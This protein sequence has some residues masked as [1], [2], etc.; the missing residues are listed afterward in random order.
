MHS[1]SILTLVEELDSCQMGDVRDQACKSFAS[2]LV[3]SQQ[4]CSF[5]HFK[6][7][8]AVIWIS[9]LLMV[10]NATFDTIPVLSRRSDLLV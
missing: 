7:P 3:V 5:I 4:I 8:T 9:V 6:N 10:F 2:S 1:M